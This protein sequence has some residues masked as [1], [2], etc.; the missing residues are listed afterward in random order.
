MKKYVFFHS[1]LD[2]YVGGSILRCYFDDFE[3]VECSY[4]SIKPLEILKQGDFVV[5]VDYSFLPEEMLWI[6]EN[7][8]AIWIDHH[9]SA[10]TSSEQ[11]GYDNLEG[12]REIGPSGAELAWKYVFKDR[13]LPKFI[14]L[15][16][17]Y[18]TFRCWGKKRFFQEVIP[19]YFG[20]EMFLAGLNP[21][22]FEKES[23][24]FCI[25]ELDKLCKKFIKLGK[26]VF[27]YKKATYSKI[28]QRNAF[29]RNLWGH[30][31]LCLNTCESGSL[32]LN[33]PETFDVSKHDMMLIYNFNGES[34]SYGFY[35]EKGKN[36]DCSAIAKLYGG[37]GHVCA[38]GCIT[39][40]LIKELQ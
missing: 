35:T 24:L 12:I 1:D 39:K 20:A 23:Y 19:F 26:V 13:P 10:I 21:K 40:E 37:G 11:Y 30:R 5:L 16:G 7:C 33:I 6:K 8:K 14:E 17:E 32:C 31:V 22:N 28:N 29:V 18:D 36:V 4:G 34:W 2:G 3:Y 27:Q 9:I 15:V 25:D 38:A